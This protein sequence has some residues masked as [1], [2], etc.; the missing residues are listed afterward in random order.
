[1]I[2]SSR[3]TASQ[4]PSLESTKL[5]SMVFHRIS[6]HSVV[7]SGRHAELTAYPASQFKPPARPNTEFKIFYPV[8]CFSL[9]AV[10]YQP[11]VLNV[12]CI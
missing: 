9:S 10:L 2:L 7:S 11:Q 5:S 8:V 6:Q 1:M 12:P 4:V 3:D